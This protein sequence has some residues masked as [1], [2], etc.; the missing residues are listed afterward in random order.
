[1]P[2]PLPEGVEFIDA[3]T[4]RRQ[5]FIN[6]DDGKAELEGPPP[7]DPHTGLP[8]DNYLKIEGLGLNR[9]K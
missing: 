1:L 2:V 6:T 4:G 5:N 7:T 3:L 8:L 9:H